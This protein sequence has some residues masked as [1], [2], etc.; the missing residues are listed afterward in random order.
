M[1]KIK[2]TKSAVDAAHPRAQAVEHRG[3]LAPGFLGKITP[4]GRKPVLGLWGTDRLT[5]TFP[6][7]RNCA[8]NSR[9][10]IPSSTTNPAPSAGMRTAA[11][12]EVAE[13]IADGTLLR[14]DSDFDKIDAAG[15]RPLRHAIAPT[16]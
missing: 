15:Q 11:K 16:R 14:S 6:R 8:R 4:A 10:T 2:L 1:A 3:T 9:R 12:A 5:G 7:S 13:V